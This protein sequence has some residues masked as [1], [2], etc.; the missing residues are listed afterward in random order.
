MY[1]RL[2]K[3][4]LVEGVRVNKESS[5]KDGIQQNLCFKESLDCHRW[6]LLILG[7]SNNT[8]RDKKV[9]QTSKNEIIKG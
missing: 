8:E 9:M 5:S 7:V 3:T 4:S 6:C 2:N 1:G